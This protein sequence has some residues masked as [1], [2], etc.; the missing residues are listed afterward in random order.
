MMLNDFD[1]VMSEINGMKVFALMEDVSF[2][3]FNLISRKK[4]SNSISAPDFGETKLPEPLQ[5]II[6]D[7][8][9]LQVSESTKGVRSN[10]F[11]GIIVEK[12][13][14]QVLVRDE[15][16]GSDGS[17]WIVT[18]TQRLCPSRQILGNGFVFRSLA[19]DLQ[20]FPKYYVYG[21]FLFLQRRYK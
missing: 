14:F 8:D 16:L 11:D 20:Y 1:G 2:D 9:L 17:N 13:F 4:K 18:Q 12:Y 19:V 7:R 5:R 10:F 21:K 6:A 3:Y 15:I